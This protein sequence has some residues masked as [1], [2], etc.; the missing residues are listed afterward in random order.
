MQD[1]I[2]GGQRTM[3]V[4]NL[5]MTLKTGLTKRPGKAASKTF[6][7]SNLKKTLTK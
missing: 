1:M 6:A 4:M 3:E 7:V 5:L 2:K